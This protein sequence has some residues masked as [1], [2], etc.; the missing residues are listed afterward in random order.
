MRHFDH[1]RQNKDF[2]TSS[3]SYIP[4]KYVY[5][6]LF[7]LKWSYFMEISVIFYALL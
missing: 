6:G 4:G 5:I 1:V 2:L 3:S 7:K